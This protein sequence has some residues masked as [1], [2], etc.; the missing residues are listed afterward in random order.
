MSHIND[1]GFIS[2]GLGNLKLLDNTATLNFPD[3]FE[4]NTDI[5]KFFDYLDY[6]DKLKDFGQFI[7]NIKDQIL[8]K[9]DNS[10][11]HLVQSNNSLLLYLCFKH[12]KNHLFKIDLTIKFEL[13]SYNIEINE[14]YMKIILFSK[15]IENNLKQLTKKFSY[16]QKFIYQ[17]ILFRNLSEKLLRKAL[18]INAGFIYYKKLKIKLFDSLK[19]FYLF[20][21]KKKILDYKSEKLKKKNLWKEFNE[22]KYL[23]KENINYNFILRDVKRKKFECKIF[24]IRFINKRSQ[25]EY[26][27][28]DNMI[29]NEEF[30]YR[31]KNIWHLKFLNFLKIYHHQISLK[32]NNY[33]VSTILKNY[34][35][36]FKVFKIL[37]NNFLAI[38]ILNRKAENFCL[39]NLKTKVLY[40]LQIHKDKNNLRK[41]NSKKFNMVNFMFLNLLSNKIY[42]NSKFKF[43]F[44]TYN[45]LRNE[46]ESLEINTKN[47]FYLRP[48]K[49]FLNILKNYYYKKLI[50]FNNLARITYKKYLIQQMNKK[51]I[52]KKHIIFSKNYK[53]KKYRHDIKRTFENLIHFKVESIIQIRLNE[54][55]RK[56]IWNKN[57]Y[58]F[59][60]KIFTAIKNSTERN[61]KTQILA[62]KMLRFKFFQ[63]VSSLYLKRHIDKSLNQY[64][65]VLMSPKNFK[66]R[67]V[68]FLQN[69]KKIICLDFYLR[70]LYKV[71]FQL[72]K[73]K[74]L[75][76]LV[77]NFKT[78]KCKI[79]YKLA[80]EKIIMVKKQNIF[81]VK[82]KNIFLNKIE[83]NINYKKLLKCATESRIEKIKKI[84]LLVLKHYYIFRKEK[85]KRYSYFSKKLNCIIKK[86]NISKF[87]AEPYNFQRMEIIFNN[88]KVFHIKENI[89]YTL[90][91]LFALKK[92]KKKIQNSLKNKYLLLCNEI[93]EKSKKY[94]KKN[95][96]IKTFIWK[97]H[98]DHLKQ[99][100]FFRNLKIDN[101]SIKSK[102]KK[103]QFWK[104]L[105]KIKSVTDCKIKKR[106]VKIK[107]YYLMI[108]K[109]LNFNLDWKLKVKILRKK[110]QKILFFKK[111]KKIMLYKYIYER[112]SKN[113]KKIVISKYYNKMSFTSKFTLLSILMNRI[114]TIYNKKNFTS[115]IRKLKIFE[116]LKILNSKVKKIEQRFFLKKLVYKYMINKDFKLVT[117]KL[118]YKYYIKNFIKGV[119]NSMIDTSLEEKMKKFINLILP[120][121]FSEFKKNVNYLIK[122]K[123]E[124]TKLKKF[125]WKNL[126]NSLIKFKSNTTI[127]LQENRINKISFSLEKQIFY[128]VSKFFFSKIVKLLFIRNFL[129][130]IKHKKY[131]SVVLTSLRKLKFSNLNFRKNYIKKAKTKFNKNI[132]S[133]NLNY[134]IARINQ[135]KLKKEKNDKTSKELQNKYGNLIKTKYFNRLKET[136]KFN[137]FYKKK[138][139]DKFF[140]E[141]NLI[142][143]RKR[144][145]KSC[146]EKIKNFKI[147]LRKN[148]FELFRNN[149]KTFTK[150]RIKLKKLKSDTD[151]FNRDISKEIYFEYFFRFFKNNMYNRQN[152]LLI[153]N[154]IIFFNTCN[155]KHQAVSKLK[156]ECTKYL[157]ITSKNIKQKI[158]LLNIRKFFHHFMIIISKL[159]ERMSILKFTKKS[160]VFETIKNFYLFNK[161]L[162][163]Y[164]MEAYN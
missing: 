41:R 162:N 14:D 64:K 21:I 49:N 160:K 128:K 114:Y 81:L 121:Y 27:N 18:C 77:N 38:K 17:K 155:L 163:K 15:Y 2:R 52:M 110:I 140:G 154:K 76:L 39:N 157:K 13:L 25:S 50:I 72:K 55:L 132:I 23:L 62:K 42:L 118:H 116:K 8:L 98:L 106:L 100:Q 104:F 80:R 75:N 151:S 156:I 150:R 46:N 115:F 120:K 26:L 37:K 92:L 11:I 90:K 29:K 102:I 129:F 32:K 133:K 147:Y 143:E 136:Y 82:I 20:S 95:T 137:I 56:I 97:L 138:I 84:S 58:I 153:K 19:K 148:K 145:S 59:V 125:Y 146:K 69:F 113:Y 135:M 96:K 48:I 87:L 40:I 70:N 22:N 4:E 68:A 103:F 112:I 159:K 67:N 61:I 1:E 35:L 101:Y 6:E 99:V 73:F 139:L 85:N 54:K 10:K 43:A 161:N 28:N 78:T 126:K 91:K 142:L 34:F 141:I 144:Y 164:L 79:F 123:N 122:L 12:G 47:Q 24:F 83:E 7:I 30:N 89:F 130:F 86:F 158:F 44:N 65:K 111:L 5:D 9:L 66:K 124:K 31:L 74:N 88:R 149:L 16:I 152:A 127:I 51:N 60:T 117:N 36:K 131:N 57:Y 93:V 45:L 94:K 108:L 3:T 63:F 53:N 33:N 71:C 105:D 107:F 134:F 109:K 119:L